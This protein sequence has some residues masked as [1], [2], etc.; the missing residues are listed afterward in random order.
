MALAQALLVG[1]GLVALSQ[2]RLLRVDPGFRAE[3]VLSFRVALPESRYSDAADRVGFLRELRDRLGALPGVVGAAVISNPPLA[4]HE[5]NFFESEEDHRAS[6]DEQRP[7][8]LTRYASEGYLDT[9][10]IP[11]RRGRDLEPATDPEAP[12]AEIVIN[13]TFAQLYWPGLDPLGRRVRAGDGPWLRVVG[14]AGDVQHYGVGEQMRPGVY[15]P[16]TASAPASTALVLRTAIEP[17]SALPA[18]RRVVRGMD[19]TLPLHRITTL[20]AALNRSLA[21]RRTA[22]TLF[23]LFAGVA[24]VL[25]AGG[26]FGV[27]SYG[28]A[29]R[30]RELGVRLALGARRGQIL[31][32]VLGQGAALAALGSALGLLVAAGLGRGLESLLFGVEA[33]DPRVLVAVSALLLGTALLANLLPAWR[34][35]RLQPMRALRDD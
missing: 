15:L 7:V 24:L 30:R 18:V 9:L 10:G 33:R 12:L 21:V 6:S 19:P 14:V 3:G 4:G 20:E 23:A 34:A 28:V 25:A 5:G 2:Q 35:S 31:G 16:L 32:L 22:A 8:T 27:V 17:L 29:R 13:E 11:L 26:A 1:A